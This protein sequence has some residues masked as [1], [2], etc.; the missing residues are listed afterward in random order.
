MVILL[1]QSI[2]LWFTLNIKGSERVTRR[3]R[4][5]S[6]IV[7]RQRYSLNYHM[8]NMVTDVG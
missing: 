2:W 3:K 6:I 8:V 1:Y 7:K 5:T 4:N